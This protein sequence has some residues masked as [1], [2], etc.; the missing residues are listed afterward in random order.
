M[1]PKLKVTTTNSVHTI[2]LSSEITATVS[3]EKKALKLQTKINKSIEH[4]FLKQNIS[5]E[6]ALPI[7]HEYINYL[8]VSE[9][10]FLLKDIEGFHAKIIRLRQ[11]EGGEN[12]NHWLLQ[13]HYYRKN[14][15]ENLLNVLLFCAK[16]RSET[17]RV[18]L[19]DILDIENSNNCIKTCF[20]ECLIKGDVSILK[21]RTA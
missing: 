7:L 17:S 9:V 3:S 20:N 16:K 1:R 11:L 19:L 6:R 10:S 21:M 12:Y 5:I 8:E 13:A 15:I 2:R 18:V 4:S 14:L